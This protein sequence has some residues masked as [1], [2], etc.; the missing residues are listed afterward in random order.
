MLCPL[1]AV[2]SVHD[3]HQTATIVLFEIVIFLGICVLPFPFETKG[4]KWS[5]TVSSPK[6]I[7]ESA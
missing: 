1:V 4:C 6:L 2:G 3:C 7:A 5:E